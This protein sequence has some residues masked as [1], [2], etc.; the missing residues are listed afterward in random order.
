MEAIQERWDF[1]YLWRQVH[2]WLPA[3]SSPS[4]IIALIHGLGDHGKRYADLAEWFCQFNIAVC[5]F[6]MIGHGESPGKRGCIRD[7]DDLLVDIGFFLEKLIDRW[8]LAATGL[9]G[10]SMGGNLVLNYALRKQ[11]L[12]AFV[13]SSAPMLR[14]TRPPSDSFLRVA[15]FMSRMAPHYRLNA[16]VNVDFL[17]RSQIAKERYRKDPLVHKQL[18][19]RLGAGLIDSGEWAIAHANALTTPT[20]LIHGD[21]DLITSHEAT[22]EFARGANENASIRIWEDQL[23]DLHWDDDREKILEFVYAW[24]VPVVESHAKSGM[25]SVN[26]PA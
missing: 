3:N 7:Y 11:M 8:P 4:A 16:P 13:I 12:P 5:S 25:G 26:L 24:L 20:L 6:D 15:R 14:A 18:S 9:Y 2:L 17:T 22:I 21:Q 10:H 1:P 23:H 19:L